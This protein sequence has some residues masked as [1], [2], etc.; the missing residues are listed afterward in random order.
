MIS[1]IV[2]LNVFSKIGQSPFFLYI[3]DITESNNLP[4]TPYGPVAWCI[5]VDGDEE[6]AIFL[7]VIKLTDH[8]N[9]W[10]F[11]PVGLFTISMNHSLEVK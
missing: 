4:E 3:I 11:K 1:L 9:T 5:F 2:H 7:R 6:S 8:S 10:Q